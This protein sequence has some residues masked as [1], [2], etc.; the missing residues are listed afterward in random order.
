MA[1]DLRSYLDLIKKKNPQDFLTISREVDPVYEITAIVTKL[2]G[3]AKRRPIVLFEKVKGCRF[4]VITNLH[5][6]R[7]RLAMAMKSAPEE[8]Q[9]AYLR[10]LDEPIA[11]KVVKKAPVKDVILKGKQINL[12]Q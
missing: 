10:A 9:S 8:T 6:S 12:Q 11:P 2:E 4:P 7:S 3:E 1:Q 5:A